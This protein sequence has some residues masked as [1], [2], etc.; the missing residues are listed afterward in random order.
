MKNV[1][2][3]EEQKRK[4]EEEK[5]NEDESMLKTRSLLNENK[6][7]LEDMKNRVKRNLE[8]LESHDIVSSKNDYQAIVNMI[9]RV[10]CGRSGS[11]LFH[12]RKKFFFLYRD[13]F[14]SI[15]LTNVAETFFSW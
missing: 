7:P 12:R 9:A 1:E 15:R 13:T 2:K 5:K 14:L 3:L 11:G 4:E 10:S 6:L 8:K